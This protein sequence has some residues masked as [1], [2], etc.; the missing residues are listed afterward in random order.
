MMTARAIYAFAQQPPPISL[1]VIDTSYVRDWQ[2]NDW[3]NLQSRH[4]PRAILKPKN[5]LPRPYVDK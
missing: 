2:I 4:Y 3:I 5:Q 1:P